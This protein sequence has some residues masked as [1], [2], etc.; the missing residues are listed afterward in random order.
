MALFLVLAAALSAVCTQAKTSEQLLDDRGRAD[1]SAINARS[2]FFSYEGRFD[3]TS[4]SD[5]VR[6]DWPCSRVSFGVD[7]EGYSDGEVVFAHK[8]LK[9]RLNAS[10]WRADG[11]IAYST[12]FSGPSA[13]GFHGVPLQEDALKIP[14]D[15]S[16]VTL[17]KL[18]QAAPYGTGIGEKLLAGSVFEFHGLTS[19]DGVTVKNAA[20]KGR[21]VEYIGA[22]DS[23]GYCVEGTPEMDGSIDLYLNGWEWDNCDLATPGLLGHHFDAELHV[24][25]EGGMGLTQNA[26]AR[27][28]AFEG[29]EP[30]PF[31][32]A[33]QTLLTDKY[34]TFDP[35]AKP[36]N[37][38]LVVI[39]LGG[40][41]YNH[42]HG[43]V[44]SNETFSEAY[45]AFL[46]SIFDA[47]EANPTTIILSVC[48]QGSPAEASFDPDN[49]RCSPCP[50]V[51]DALVDFKAKHA[52]FADRAELALVPCDGS[53]VTGEGDIGCNGH[54]NAVGQRE[55][56]EHIKPIVSNLLNW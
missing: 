52:D 45:E 1:T 44:P 10:A 33:K 50:H 14:S 38:D 11:T 3:F 26:N 28:P 40:N 13:E 18:T 54:K 8:S 42:Q 7:V 2:D 16:Y 23:A 46:L 31:F 43:N 17:R 32:W 20:K 35:K 29:E 24:E 12:I 34:P 19:V 41:D 5:S 47:Y 53:V 39:S 27:I 51:E 21:V 25:A 56:F 4:S 37:P 15:S 6:S 9:S 30:L 22:S 49:N 55:V 36:L 48:G